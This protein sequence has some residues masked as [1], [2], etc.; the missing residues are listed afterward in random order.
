MWTV[1]SLLVL[2]LLSVSAL[3]SCEWKK[4][5]SVDRIWDHLKE[6]ETIAYSNGGN[7]AAGN[8]GYLASIEYVSS[9][10]KEHTDYHIEL[11]PFNF[12][13]TKIV[14]T[15]TFSEVSPNPVHYHDGDDFKVFPASPSSSLTAV[16]VT[17]PELGCSSSDYASFPKGAIALVAR[18]SCSF[19]EKSALAASG[20]ASGVLIYNSPDGLAFNGAMDESKIPA[21]ALSHQV[22]LSLF[23][24]KDV[25][26]SI[27]VE[28]SHTI[29]KTFNLIAETKEGNPDHVIIVGSHLDSVPA[30][31][32][33]NDNGSGSSTNL[34]LALATYKCREELSSKVRFAWWGAEEVGLLGSHFYVDNL[35]ATNATALLDIA[36]N[37][38]FDMTAS[39]NYEFGV[40]DGSSGPSPV[41]DGSWAIQKVFESIFTK[42]KT[43]YTLAAF[44]GRS[45]YGPFI[46]EGIPAGGLATGAEVVK[47]ME[48]RSKFGGLANT[49][50]DPCYH[51]VCDTVENISEVAISANLHIAAQALQTLSTDASLIRKI[52]KS[53]S[54]NGNRHS[55]QKS[56]IARSR[57]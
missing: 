34:E 25:T 45:D 37:L 13:Q 30:G 20:G 52:H 26:V 2:S 35:K 54:V 4:H 56:R 24:R 40:Y 3:G 38:N 5:V 10:L 27:T 12:K 44:T 46:E 53:S 28:T 31:P 17:V 23:E 33:I 29:V 51:L 48:G 15:P 9:V 16:V 55:Y 14:G 43:P 50:F 1:T 7:R 42:E 47:D 22:G 21:V 36:L 41:R 18:G 8:P 39:P 49:P 57:D 19:A 32:G 6:L 11:Q